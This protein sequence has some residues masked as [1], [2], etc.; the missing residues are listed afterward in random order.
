MKK[1]YEIIGNKLVPVDK[2]DSTIEV[3]YNPTELE[4][5]ISL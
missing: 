3:Y 5:K 1:N 2:L 4:K